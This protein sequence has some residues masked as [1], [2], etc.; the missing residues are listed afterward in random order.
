MPSAAI[1]RTYKKNREEQSISSSK[2]R[3]QAG[4][5]SCNSALTFYISYLFTTEYKVC[6]NE[7]C[8]SRRSII[9]KYLNFLFCCNCSNLGFSGLVFRVIYLK[10]SN[11]TISVE[12]PQWWSCLEKRINRQV[13]FAFRPWGWYL[14]DF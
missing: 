3:Q 4:S 13:W 14:E 2:S 12:D 5:I 9:E 8:T 11:E 1:K 7:F 6:T 10:N